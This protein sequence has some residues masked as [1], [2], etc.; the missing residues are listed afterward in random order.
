MAAESFI[1]NL[2]QVVT[3]SVA[4]LSLKLTEPPK[5][6]QSNCLFHVTARNPIDPPKDITLNV[7][8]RSSSAEK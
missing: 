1:Q 2:H 7:C 5:L 8:S 6:R 3:T 4:A